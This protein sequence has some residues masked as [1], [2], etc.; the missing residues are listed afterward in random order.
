M[1]EFQS[2]ISCSLVM[3]HG[4]YGVPKKTWDAWLSLDTE[5]LLLMIRACVDRMRL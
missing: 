4:V 2:K 1:R 5:Q 3:K